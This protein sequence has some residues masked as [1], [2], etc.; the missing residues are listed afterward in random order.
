[1]TRSGPCSC[2]FPLHNA[3]C[4][5][6]VKT[7]LWMR[8][9]L[10]TAHQLGNV[11]NLVLQAK[12]PAFPEWTADAA[13]DHCDTRGGLGGGGAREATLARTAG[14]DVPIIGTMLDAAMDRRRTERTRGVGGPK[15]PRAVGRKRRDAQS[16][17]AARTQS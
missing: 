11:K 9:Q 12:P 17:G 16:P 2:K 5:P 6:T 10:P 4:I 14:R 15:S 13:G 7:V 1:M 8:S 3:L